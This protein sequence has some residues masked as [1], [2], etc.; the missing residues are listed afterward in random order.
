M[1]Q[2]DGRDVLVIGGG[3]AGSV[4]A[5]ALAREGLRVRLI[6]GARFPR[7]HV[8]ESLTPSCRTVLDVI[9]ISEK[10]DAHGFVLKHGGAIRWDSDAW[11]FDWGADMGV[12]SWQ[13]DRADFD[14]LLLEHARENGVQVST[15]VTVKSVSFTGKR[16]ASV[17][18]APDDGEPY[19]I[20]DFDYLID[21]TGRAGLLSAQH[22]NTRRSEPALRN[23][24]IWGYWQDTAV[25]PDTPPGGINIISSPAG[26][27]WIIPL[28]GGRTSIGFVTSKDHFAERRPAAGSLDEM[29][30]A[31]VQES[32]TVRG[33]TDGA[34][35]AGPV[36]AETD[37]SYAAERFCGPGYMIV[38][39][40][41]C[42]LDPLLSTGVHLA[43]YSALNAAACIASVS[44][45]EVAEDAASAFFEFSYRRAYTR[46]FALV[47]VMYERYLGK[48]G[49]FRVSDRLVG[50]GP[51]TDGAGTTRPSSQ[52][53]VEIITGLSD[54]R[55]ATDTSTRVITEQLIAEA[56]RSQ[57][58]QAGDHGMPDFS[59]VLENPLRDAETSDYLLTTSPRLGLAKAT[60][61]LS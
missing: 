5:T 59:S 51:D 34:R 30:Y 2:R 27:Y 25:L 55:E 7:Y 18:C 13:V 47:S 11:F 60:A 50:A 42:F 46:L 40:A 58:D 10:L 38:G 48:D 19:D 17:R 9:G 29:Y 8:G 1:L 4:A 45:D 56:V 24:A 43:L 52:S 21:A 15:G 32:A 61:A 28:A 12:H 44:R 23:I 31:L 14:N 33:L 3:P 16:P 54:L 39:D 6:E 36:R 53:F 22:L 57:H 49:F 26:W 37:Y 35:Y 41:A 20:D